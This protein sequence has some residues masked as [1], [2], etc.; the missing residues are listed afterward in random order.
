MWHI[1]NAAWVVTVNIITGVLRGQSIYIQ[2][3]QRAR[4]AFL[5][6]GM[7]RWEADVEMMSW[8]G[9]RD[10]LGEK[11]CAHSTRD[12]LWAEEE[13][14]PLSPPEDHVV[15]LRAL[16]LWM[17]AFLQTP[18]PPHHQTT[19][20]RCK[21]KWKR[22]NTRGQKLLSAWTKGWKATL[23]ISKGKPTSKSFHFPFCSLN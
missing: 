12:E 20:L 10:K 21:G 3:G 13:L 2:L 19:W 17:A 14:R 15:V 8:Q 16:H 7:G 23:D 11:G 22:F 4:D 6:W 5:R 18:S 9:G 1:A